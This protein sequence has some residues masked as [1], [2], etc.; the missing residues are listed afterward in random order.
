MIPIY[1]SAKLLPVL[2]AIHPPQAN[3]NAHRT[4]AVLHAL[5]YFADE[6]D[7]SAKAQEQYGK[8]VEEIARRRA[9]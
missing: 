7:F 9:K 8:I 3:V 2:N 6:A 5:H 4:G 1:R